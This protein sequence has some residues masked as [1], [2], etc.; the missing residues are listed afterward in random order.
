[1][2]MQSVMCGSKVLERKL[3]KYWS[4]LF[5]L[6]AA[7]YHQR[8]NQPFK[9]VVIDIAH[10]VKALTTEPVTPVQFLGPT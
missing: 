10:P 6:G 1:M 8:A 4:D 5:Q 2:W 7:W 3:E 9:T